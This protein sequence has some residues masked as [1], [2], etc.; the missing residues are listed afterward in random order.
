MKVLIQ[1]QEGY[2]PHVKVYADWE[3]ANSVEILDEWI[4]NLQLA[5]AWLKKANKK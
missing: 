1:K 5:K 4:K 2:E 3:V